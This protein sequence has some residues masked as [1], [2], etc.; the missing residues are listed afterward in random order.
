VR[1]SAREWPPI[2][3]LSRCRRTVFF[4]APYPLNSRL[5]P[6]VIYGGFAS[7]R[8][9]TQSDP[10]GL[11][12]GI[13]TY[14]YVG[15]NPL[16]FVDP[17]GLDATVCLYPG[18]GG[19][20]H[21]G[22][23]VNSSSTV[24]LYPRSEAPGIAAITGTPAAVKADTKQAEQCK[25]VSTSAEQDKKMADF[26]QKTTQNPGTYAL[27]GNNCTAFVRAVLDQAGVLTATTPAPRIYFP[28]L[29]GK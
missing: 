7:G 18:A 4:I 1:A 5:A 17:T 25:T 12:G 24:G 15:G 3:S 2:R 27:S 22:I 19:A 16:S 10:I 13:N 8:I 28:A 11:A 26:I 9:Y 6:T 29:P 21:V 14:S 20:G 23:G